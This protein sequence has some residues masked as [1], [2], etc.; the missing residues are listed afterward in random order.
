MNFAARDGPV[1]D[2]FGHNKNL[3]GIEGNRAIPQLDVE[4]ALEDEKEIVGVL[5]FVPMNGPSSLATMMSL[6]L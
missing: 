3:A 1:L 4:R 6:L 2:A 5:M